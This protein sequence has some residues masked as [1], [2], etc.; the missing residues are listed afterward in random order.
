MSLKDIISSS[1]TKQKLTELLAN[2]LLTMYLN[3]TSIKVVVTYGNKIKGSDFVMEH[4]Y[5]EADTLI[6][7]KVLTATLGH[8]QCIIHV[9]SPDTH[10]FLLLMD[11]VSNGLVNEGVS[12]ILK[13][14]KGS[15]YRY[16][17]KHQ[18]TSCCSWQD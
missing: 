6:P 12:V 16:I 17:Y 9:L 13:T 4:S 5:E 15:Q 8:C 14:G 3:E 1:E 18:S 11:L 2:E 10:V 7:H